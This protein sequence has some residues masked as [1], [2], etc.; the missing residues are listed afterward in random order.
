MTL[1]GND[2]TDRVGAGE[3]TPRVFLG[4]LEREGDALAVEIDV[5]NLDGDLVAHGDDPVGVI[6]VLPRQLGH[7]DQAVDAAQI[8]EGAEVDD[9]GHDALCGPGPSGAGAGN[10]LRTSDWVCSSQARRREHHV[11]AVLPSSMILA[12]ISLPMYG[13][14]S[15]TRRISTSDA[16]R[17]P[18]RP[19]SRS[20]R[21]DDLDDGAL[22][23][24][25]LLFEL[26]D[27]APGAL[28]LGALSG[29][30]QAAF[31]LLGEDQRLDL[32]ADV[33][34]LAGVDV[35][36][37][38]EFAGRNDAFGLVTDVKQNLVAVDLDDR[39]LNDVAI[40]EVLDRGI[41]GGEKILGRADVVDGYLRRGDSGDDMCGLFRTGISVGRF[42]LRSSSRKVLVNNVNTTNRIC[43]CH[44]RFQHYARAPSCTNGPSSLSEVTV[45]QSLELIF[46][47][48]GDAS[49][50]AEVNRLAA[51]GLRN[52]HRDQ[53]PH[54]T[55]VAA[56]AIDPAA[57]SALTPV[58]QRLPI[59]VRLGAPDCLL[60]RRGR[61]A[62]RVRAGAV[63]APSTELLGVHATVLR[64]ADD[65]LDGETD[66]CRPGQW[67]PHVTLARRLSAEQL[68]TA[69]NGLRRRGPFRRR[70]R[71][72]T[73]GRRGEDRVRPTWKVVLIH[74]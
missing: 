47:V 28:V 42:V 56:T 58:A 15:R 51:A 63:G 45:V 11:V 16:G 69:L 5:E 65:H 54:I 52:P 72:P 13:C 24:L 2:L 22:D 4:R 23:G 62:W 36:L 27:R 64:L 19:M 21:P 31:V 61:R 41:D 29:Q 74:G 49:V 17:K 44:T 53:R 73:V 67:A 18:R 66:H 10:S 1:P 50:I 39:P 59:T 68:A 71:D 38:G 7:V 55:L 37:D 43:P 26:L 60:P 3:L 57:L 8:D 25:V 35:V 48:D 9:G 30:D 33:D 40:V 14:R 6:D 70:R 20:G 34:D 12:S 32:I 46:D